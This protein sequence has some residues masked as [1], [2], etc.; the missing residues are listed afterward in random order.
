MRKKILFHSN[1]SKLKTGFGRHMRTILTYLYNTGKYDLV[2]YAAA[3]F[4]WSDSRLKG[5]PWK[6]YGALP[7]QKDGI[8]PRDEQ[9]RMLYSYGLTNLDKVIKLEKPDFYFGIEDIWGLHSIWKRQWFNKIHSVIWTPIDSVPLLP[10]QVEAAKASENF[11]VKAEFAEKALIKKGINHVKTIPA[12]IDDTPFYPLKEIERKDLRYK[13]GVD[14]DTFVVGFVFRNQI[15][16]LV[17]TLFDGVKLFKDKYPDKKIKIL[18]HTSWAEG[19]NI[20][21]LLNNIGLTLDDVITTHICYNC[22]AIKIGKFEGHKTDCLACGEKSLFTVGAEKGVTE[23]ELNSIYNICDAYCH[24]M[25][26]GGF[27][28]PI[29]EAMYAGLPVITVPYSCGTTYTDNQDVYAVE[30]SYYRDINTG[31]FFKAQPDP[32]SVAAAL[33]FFAIQQTKEENIARGLRLREWALEK[34]QCHQWLKFIEDFI[35]SRDKVEYNFDLDNKANIDYQFI[36]YP[37]HKEFIH[38]T[39]SGI[40]NSSIDEESDDF[41]LLFDAANKGVSHQKIYEKLIEKANE[42]NDSIKQ[43]ELSDILPKSENKQLL[44]IM[45]QRL[46]DCLISLDII[47][48]IIKEYKGWDIHIAT[49]PEY[50][51][52][53]SHIPEV[54]S[55]I[56]YDTWMDSFKNLEGCG[57][58]NGI[59]DVAFHP[60]FQ[61]QKFPSY[62]HNGLSI[63]RLN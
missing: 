35:D 36:D 24:L 14:D 55:V 32:K 33:E 51:D 40:F 60:Y 22:N 11:W 2:E 12:L 58:L 61:T 7:D 30:C 25:T 4:Q 23:K 63:E 10:L 48:A 15:R 49:M 17:G 57:K 47:Q 46:G 21:E 19:W 39:I 62:S 56:Q 3:P 53:F 1:G 20:P 27:E 41:K 29:L 38:K 9:E 31:G 5:L 45:P 34:F 44:Y 59:V 28:M 6:A 37:N 54:K 8:V 42:R 50:F 13:V 16:K 52:V 18:L 26:S 43:T